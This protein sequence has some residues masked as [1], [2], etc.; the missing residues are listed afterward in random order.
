M[1]QT[2]KGVILAAGY[3]T[4]F[5]PAT[6]T[7]PKGMIP[8]LNR[9]SIDYIIQDFITAGI[10]EILVVTSRRKKV[11]DD[12][13]DREVELEEV[14]KQ[15]EKTALFQTIQPPD[16]M[17]YFLRQP[18]MQ[19]TGH[20]L[21]LVRDFVGNHPFLVA[22][23][24]D[25][26]L[27]SP[28]IAECLVEAY[29]QTHASVL[30]SMEMPDSDV[31]MYG[32]FEVEPVPNQSVIPVRKLVEKPPIGKEPSKLISLGWYLYTPE[33]FDE[34]QSDWDVFN[35]RE[36]SG[37]FNQIAAVNRLA[38][39]GRIFTHIYQ[40]KRIDIGNMNGYLKAMTHLAVHHPTFGSAY[41]SYLQ[42]LVAQNFQDN[43]K[44]D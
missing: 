1:E 2:I 41:R 18:R 39:K 31:S 17:V 25:I 37:E 7:V 30:A 27:G 36:S 29:D 3:G 28:S 8:L 16:V 43:P 34:M 24:D 44:S 4:R 40:D 35:R 6:K 42:S 21:M 14:F 22:Y 9:P 12:Y 19:G 33:L 13:F 26:S 5:L 38:Q 23:P 32:V 11:L 10:R 15:E 20:A